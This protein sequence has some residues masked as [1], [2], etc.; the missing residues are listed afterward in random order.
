[1]AHENMPF[2]LVQQNF[3]TE[4]EAVATVN[5]MAQALGIAQF[6][7]LAKFLI[8]KDNVSVVSSLVTFTND[9]PNGMWSTNHS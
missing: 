1:M 6:R 7:G 2:V 4:L 5:A 3:T 8:T 9:M